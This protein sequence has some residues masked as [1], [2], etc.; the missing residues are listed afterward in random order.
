MYM[1]RYIGSDLLFY[2]FFNMF[3]YYALQIMDILSYVHICSNFRNIH[4]VLYFF[5]LNEENGY[6][7]KQ[8]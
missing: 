4:I 6:I 3:M 2:F 5:Q 1:Y 8:C 7:F